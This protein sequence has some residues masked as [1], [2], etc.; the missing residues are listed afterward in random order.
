MLHPFNMFREN[1]DSDNGAEVLEEEC[2][3][4]F[5]IKY[6]IMSMIAMLLV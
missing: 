4:I 6:V 2:N 3:R 1:K 5:G